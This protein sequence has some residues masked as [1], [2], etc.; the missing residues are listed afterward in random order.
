ME[1]LEALVRSYL[2]ESKVGMIMRAYECAK[3]A[4]EGQFRRSGDPYIIHPVAVAIILGGL[5]M[6]H[7]TIMAAL[8]HDVIEDTEVTKEELAGQFGETVA[9]LVDGEQAYPDRV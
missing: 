2:D 8:L 3:E 4:H 5:H 7:E 6:D 9:D 1:S